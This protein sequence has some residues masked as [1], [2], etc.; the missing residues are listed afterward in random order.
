MP[1]KQ[2]AEKKLNEKELTTLLTLFDLY[3][4]LGIEAFDKICEK[5]GKKVASAVL[6]AYMSKKFGGRK[7]AVSM[8]RQTRIFN[9]A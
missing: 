3:E 4:Q 2:K 8:I 6:I 1:N 5:H 7:Q 9:V